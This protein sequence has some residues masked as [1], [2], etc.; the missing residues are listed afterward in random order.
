MIV[1]AKE[2]LYTK[3]QFDNMKSELE[4]MTQLNA[5]SIIQVYGY[6]LHDEKKDQVYSA[7]GEDEYKHYFNDNG[8]SRYIS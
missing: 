3:E 6:S 4:I 5:D 8:E 7:E 2:C 1:A